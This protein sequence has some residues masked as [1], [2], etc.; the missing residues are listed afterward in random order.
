MMI[1]KYIVIKFYIIIKHTL[2]MKQT[3]YI[4]FISKLPK[5]SLN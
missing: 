3:D 1:R 4:F 2:F 5:W